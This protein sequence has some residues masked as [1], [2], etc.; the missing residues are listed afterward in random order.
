MDDC[1]ECGERLLWGGM[2]WVPHTE[3][4]HAATRRRLIRYLSRRLRAR[5][6]MA[7]GHRITIR[8]TAD[9]AWFEC[10]C[11]ASGTLQVDSTYASGDAFEHL[12]NA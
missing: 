2:S 3:R 12:V 4:Q 7:A 9:W 5:A 6:S 11:D 10:S 8:F 1:V